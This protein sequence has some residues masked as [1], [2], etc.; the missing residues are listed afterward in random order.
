VVW[1]SDLIKKV[2][3]TDNPV[4]RAVYH[5]FGSTTG[6][7]FVVDNVES[8]NQAERYLFKGPKGKF[9]QFLKLKI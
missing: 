1:T 8:Y 5:W 2:K 6:V 3:R 4:S 9:L 7:E